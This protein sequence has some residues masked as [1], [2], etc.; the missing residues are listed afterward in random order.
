MDLSNKS[1]LLVEDNKTAQ[2]LCGIYF[3]KM[4][5]EN[6]DL[7]E[8]GKQ[9]VE[10]ATQKLYDVILMDIEMPIMNGVDATEEIR[11]L[12]EWSL[13]KI[14]AYTVHETLSNQDTFDWKIMKP[15]TI[16]KFTNTIFDVLS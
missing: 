11:R 14:I 9:A 2:H 15:T 4:W 13:V 5:I 16:K 12:E 1:V 6:I 10:K 8:N 3:K 7:A